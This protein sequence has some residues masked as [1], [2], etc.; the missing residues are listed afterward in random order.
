MSIDKR[1]IEQNR[2][3]LV[4]YAL[5]IL[6]AGLLLRSQLFVNE[7]FPLPYEL[8]LL[9]AT[10]ISCW[11]LPVYWLLGGLLFYLFA[12]EPAA[13]SEYDA[14][15]V[16]TTSLLILAL[17]FSVQRFQILLRAAGVQR[18]R[19]LPKF[20]S[21]VFQ[22]DATETESLDD[23]MAPAAMAVVL[24]LSGLIVC[25]A[26]ASVILFVT[27]VDPNAAR[28]VRLLPSALR[29]IQLGF[30]VCVTYVVVYLFL[31]EFLWRRNSKQQASLYLRSVSFVWLFRDL[32]NIAR[33]R[34]KQRRRVKSKISQD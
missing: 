26:L 30:L 15:G 31:S 33:A 9:L 21:A 13:V 5:I 27:P 24:F 1:K 2:L 34:D 10:L 14:T 29:A 8:C 20:V 28:N 17:V 7:F 16:F 18:L 3:Q 6:V 25:A 23:R 19:Q 12:S 4:G 22:T 32:K 11:R